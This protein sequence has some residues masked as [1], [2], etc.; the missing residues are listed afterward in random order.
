MSD[1]LHMISAMDGAL[2]GL[3]GIG[4][5][6]DQHDI[7]L[8]VHLDRDEFHECAAKRPLPELILLDALSPEGRGLEDCRRLK[9]NAVTRDI[10][11]IIVVSPQDEQTR[12]AGFAAGAVD[13]VS[14]LVSAAELVARIKRHIELGAAQAHLR[15]RNEQ[16][17]TALASMGQGVCLFDE[18]ARLLL[19][20]NR[21]AEVYGLDPAVIHPGQSLEDILKLRADV[22]AVPATSTSDYLAWAVATNMG[23]APQDWIKE[24]K[25]GQIIRG[26]HQRTPEGGW[27][28]THED[29][30]QAWFA[31]KA[32]A[33]AH[34]QAERAEQEAR[35]A[36][37]RLLA[38][39]EVVPEG[40]VLFDAEDR[41]VLWNRR[42]EQL[43]AESGDMLVKGMR[44]ED[45]L[46]TG[47]ECGQYPEAVGREQE[48]L[49]ERLARHAEPTS[50]HE[51]R[52]PGNRWIRIEE[53]RISEGGSV[54]IRV[55]ITDLK[56]QEASFRLLFE[57][58]PM[59]MWVYDRETL[60]FLHVNQAAIDHYGYRLEQF[61]TMTLRDIQAPQD[62][63]RAT[64]AVFDAEDPAAT[65]CSFRHLKADGGAIE[66][67]V[68]ST[69]LNH[70]GKA[71]SLMAVVDVTEAKRAEKALLQHRDTLEEMVRSRTVELAR[72]TEELERMLEQEKQINELQRQFVSMASHEF[73]TP[74][75]VI[76]G[77][78]QRLIRRK[79]AATPEFLAE[80]ADQIRSSVSRMLE[81]M[82]SIL[83]AGRLDHGRIT[84]VPK[85]CSIAE[86]IETCSARQESI[87]RSHRFLLKLDELPETIYGDRPALDQV[88]SNLFS[89]AVKYA[90][91]SPNVHVSGWQ[92]GERVCITVRDE[93]IGIDADDLP[94]MFQRYFRARSSTGIAGTGIG[95]NLVKQIVELH[96]GT[97]DVASSRGNGTTFTLRIPIGAEMLDEQRVA[98]G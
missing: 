12:I 71:A 84:I 74:L 20:N 22:G 46:R 82:E 75:A 39:F 49:E 42:Y 58:N 66:V 61:L 94:K 64:A 53:R 77:A 54:G 6:L 18:D 17:D 63:D 90:P 67:T 76:D 35:A 80:K 26:Y 78:A 97:I 95:L 43:Y 13:C 33:E 87:R 28:S 89:N 8:G 57:G 55:D 48:W 36:H 2:T 9:G 47:L 60:K 21:Y 34:A 56:M 83:A 23:D 85:P 70:K 86:I 44:F 96:G 37:A 65:T 27:V 79:E 62:A 52:L 25:T 3:P 31:E 73:R 51:Q 41:F 98:T 32:L 16:L 45:R 38:A 40:L 88:F 10:P 68:Y 69:C 92:E 19:S 93:G 4:D 11:V 15:R 7:V 91:D 59:P 29:I 30:T 72:Q 81:L 50:K 14:N 5:C 1:E 24:L